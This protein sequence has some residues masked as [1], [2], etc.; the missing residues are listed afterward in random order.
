MSSKAGR[1]IYYYYYYHCDYYPYK[2]LIFEPT[3]S[4]KPD[5]ELT[6]INTRVEFLT[7]SCFFLFQ[8]LRAFMPKFLCK[9]QAIQV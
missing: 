5:L 4:Y 7:C 1:I 9:K 8:T 6:C 2:G 3:S